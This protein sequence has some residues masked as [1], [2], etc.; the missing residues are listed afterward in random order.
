[1]NSALKQAL[2][3]QC[4]AS[5]MGNPEVSKEKKQAYKNGYELLSDANELLESSRIKHEAASNKIGS[6]SGE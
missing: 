6:G 4:L 5:I 1:M 3:T 2:L